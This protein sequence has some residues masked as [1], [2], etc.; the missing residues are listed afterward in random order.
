MK[1]QK[2]IR[3][4]FDFFC[5]GLDVL[6][7]QCQDESEVMMLATIMMEYARKG[8]CLAAGS[9]ELGNSLM[10]DYINQQIYSLPEGE[11]DDNEDI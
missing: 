11:E 7:V 1:S 9:E 6:L 10:F 3:A 5:D 8:L 2:F 4:R